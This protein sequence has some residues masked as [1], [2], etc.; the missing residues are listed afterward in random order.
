MIE[1]SE[2]RKSQLA[3]ELQNSSDFEKCSKAIGRVSKDNATSNKNEKGH[4]GLNMT[5]S[6]VSLYH[7]SRFLCAIGI[8][9]TLTLLSLPIIRT[10]S[11]MSLPGY[12]QL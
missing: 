9:I 10:S 3:F 8:V 1:G 5:P 2:K 7:S 4:K 11:A 6:I 12:T